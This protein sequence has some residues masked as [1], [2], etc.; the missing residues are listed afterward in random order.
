[1]MPHSARVRRQAGYALI[2]VAGTLSIV[3]LLLTMAAVVLHRSMQSHQL[4]L[5]QLRHSQ[6]LHALH[7]ALRED[8]HQS[9]Q[10]GFSDGITLIQTDS[11]LEYRVNQG[12]VERIRRTAAG[13]V[14]AHES[15]DVGIQRLELEIDN[16]NEHPLAV[17]RLQF[18]PAPF[19]PERAITWNFQLKQQQSTRTESPSRQPLDLTDMPELQNSG[20]GEGGDE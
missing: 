7:S 10:A 13:A 14:V 12:V 15:W 8:S 1:M 17:F 19:G 20:S 11:A 9:S 16:S 3:G 5:Q 18:G 6:L 2:E 4:A